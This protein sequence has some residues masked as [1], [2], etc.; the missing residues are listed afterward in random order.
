M[1][2]ATTNR[3]LVVVSLAVLLASATWFSGTAAARSLAELWALDP[4]DAAW[5]TNATQSGFIVGTLLYALTNLADRHDA[6]RVFFVSAG[7]GAVFNLGF[8]W[9]ADGLASALPFR[10]LTGV[11]LAGVYPVGMKIIASRYRE[12]PGW[13][14]GVMVGCLTLGTAFPYG[15]D[16]L[17]LDLEWRGL[18]TVASV[19]ALGGGALILLGVSEDTGPGTRA[20]LDL[21]MMVNVFRHAPFRNTAFGYFGHMWELYA[22]W[23]FAGFFVAHSVG[24]DPTWSARVPLFAFATVAMGAVGCVVGGWVSRRTSERGVAIVSMLV[25]MCMCLLSGLFFDMP[26]PWLLAFL[27]VWGFFVVSDSPQLSALAALNAP[28][29]YTATALTIHNGAGFLVTTIAIQVVPLIAAAVGW[30]WAFTG[31]AI[32]P[33]IGA[34]FTFL[35]PAPEPVRK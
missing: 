16:A 27:L 11:T 12:D 8:A 34:V 1:T 25:S 31:L 10:F 30:Q 13:R 26:P 9:L 2:S 6:R 19:A 35:V 17:G 24:D 4:A 22:L 5:L 14:L 32:G 7:L 20:R 28:P 21:R 29:G 18:A 23:A 33:A 3:A 15:I